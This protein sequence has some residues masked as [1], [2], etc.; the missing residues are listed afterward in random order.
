[1]SL[2]TNHRDDPTGVQQ[3]WCVGT[4]PDGEPCGARAMRGSDFCYWHDPAMEEE[5][6]NGLVHYP[7]T[8]TPILSEAVPLESL[9]DLEA[10]LRRVAIQVVTG[11]RVETRR[12]TALNGLAS[13]LTKVIKIREL[14]SQLK[15]AEA[16][17]EQ[18]RQRCVDYEHMLEE[19]LGLQ[20]VPSD[21][22]DGRQ[23]KSVPVSR[24][25]DL[26]AET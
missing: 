20:R 23:E 5:R 2:A 6:V 19:A 8:G 11:Q 25:N 22:T 18:L 14:Q 4:K 17:A 26:K 13:Q 9:A 12:V 1:M 16:E 10:L 7:R 15:D 24:D 21:T 3:I